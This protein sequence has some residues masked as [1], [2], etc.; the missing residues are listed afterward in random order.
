MTQNKFLTRCSTYEIQNKIIPKIHALKEY[1]FAWDYYHT[2]FCLLD[3]SPA[4]GAN[5]R[6][7]LIALKKHGI[8]THKTKWCEWKNEKWKKNIYILWMF[9]K[10]DCIENNGIMYCWL[11]YNCDQGIPIKLFIADCFSWLNKVLKLI[12]QLSALQP[13]IYQGTVLWR[14]RNFQTVLAIY[15]QIRAKPEHL[16]TNNNYLDCPFDAGPSWRQSLKG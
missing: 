6:T 14:K 13:N 11:R 16:V 1:L 8:Y 9:G 7:K 4:L 2:I 10:H 3:S 15:T 12:L 5:D